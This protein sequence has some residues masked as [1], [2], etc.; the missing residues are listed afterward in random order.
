MHKASGS[1]GLFA[2]YHRRVDRLTEQ[3]CG[4]GFFSGALFS[5]VATLSSVLFLYS[6]LP[7][8]R[9]S[10]FGQRLPGGLFAEAGE[11]RQTQMTTE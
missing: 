3:T 4:I 1:A 6:Y 5:P 9:Q 10:I 11:R 8:K 2:R 7:L